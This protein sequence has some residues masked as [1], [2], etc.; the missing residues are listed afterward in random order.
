ML[1]M[2]LEFGPLERTGSQAERDRQQ[3]SPRAHLQ[4]RRPSSQMAAR[5]RRHGG[6]PLRKRG[7]PKRNPTAVPPWLAELI[8]RKPTKV[9]AVAPANKMTCTAWAPLA[10]GRTL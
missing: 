9:S 3:G 8:A 6:V 1:L 10:P 7:G 4:T 5:R 2:D